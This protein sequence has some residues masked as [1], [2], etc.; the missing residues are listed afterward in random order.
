MVDIQTLL[1]IFW[2]GLATATYGVLLAAAFSLVLKEIHT[3][4]CSARQ[5]ETACRTLSRR[6][7]QM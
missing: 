6:V 3:L 7:S 5:R 1:Q 4:V 2:T